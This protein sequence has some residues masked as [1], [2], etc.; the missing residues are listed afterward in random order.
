MPQA[1]TFFHLQV[2]GESTAEFVGWLCNLQADCDYS[3]FSKDIDLAYALATNCVNVETQKLLLSTMPINLE[4]FLNI[5]QSIEA[6]EVGSAFL[7]GQP[8]IHR[9]YNTQQRSQWSHTPDSGHCMQNSSVRHHS[10]GPSKPCPN[11]GCRHSRE[12]CPT[13]GKTCDACRKKNHFA[14]ACH[15]SRKVKDHP[16]DICHVTLRQIHCQ[17]PTDLTCSIELRLGNR[18]ALIS[19]VLDTGATIM[20]VPRTV[21]NKVW[22]RLCLTGTNVK[23]HNFDGT[24]IKGFRGMFQANLIYG[25]KTTT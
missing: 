12:H 4:S 25:D 17:M 2:Q 24:L 13:K 16:P 23:L 18:K 8:S 14:A 15:S 10:P 5:M 21:I 3:N 22:P 6:S 9:V 11:C 19:G 20:I 1:V 7:Q